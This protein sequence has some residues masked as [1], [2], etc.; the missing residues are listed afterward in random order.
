MGWER[1]RARHDEMRLRYWGKILRMKEER[2]VKIVYKESKERL[3]REE[4][5]LER[6]EDVQITNTWCKYTR[7][8]LCELQLGHKWATQVVPSEAEWNK[9]VRDHIHAREQV[10]WRTSCLLKPKLRTYSKIKK[11]LRSEPFLDVY[12]R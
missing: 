9:R 10:V 2:L 3:E 7:D 4:R 11:E 6:G 8:L 12:H 1:Q 5:E